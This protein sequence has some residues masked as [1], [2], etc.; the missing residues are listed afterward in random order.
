MDQSG[1][2]HVE[3]IAEVNWDNST[4]KVSPVKV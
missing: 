1:D 4:L 2:R 3:Q